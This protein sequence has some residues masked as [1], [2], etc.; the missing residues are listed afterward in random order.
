M[1][2]LTL[3]LLVV[4]GLVMIAELASGAFIL[5]G[6]GI[7][8]ILLAVLAQVAGSMGFTILSAVC[9]LAWI[10]ITILLRMLFGAA[11]TE[12]PNTYD[13]EA[14]ARALGMS[15]ET[16]GPAGPSSKSRDPE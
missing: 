4:A 5:L 11:R 14:L 10:G 8:L 1:S 15:I 7:A 12:D 9:L 6:L 13:R 3:L 16:N 2:S